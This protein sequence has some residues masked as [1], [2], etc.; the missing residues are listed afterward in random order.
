MAGTKDAAQALDVALGLALDEVNGFRLGQG[1]GVLVTALEA[2]AEAG[3]TLNGAHFV[4][5]RK[6]ADKARE[7]WPMS[8]FG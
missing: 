8:V 4:T 7:V 6:I 5:V 2:A 3:V 1:F